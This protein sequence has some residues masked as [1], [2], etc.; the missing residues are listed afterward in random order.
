MSSKRGFSLFSLVSLKNLVVIGMLLVLFLSSAA[1]ASPIIQEPPPT[2]ASSTDA[3]ALWQ[4]YQARFTQ[5]KT[6]F[7][8]DP[9]AALF[10]PVL[11]T[12]FVSSDGKTAVLWLA[13][14]DHTGRIL[15]TEPGIVFALRQGE[16]W[17]IVFSSDEEWTE[18]KASLPEGF[19][20]AEFQSAPENTPD[21][22]GT[23]YL[24]GYYL[25]YVAGTVHRLEGS[26][27]HFHSYPPLGYPSCDVAY[28]RYVYDFTDA[29]H[30]PLVASKAGIVISS[31][32][33]CIDGNTTCTN[34]IILQ[35]TVGSAYQ[36]YLH[37][38]NNTISDYLTAGTF[39]DRGKYIG[40]TDD[41]GYSTSEHVH[42]MIVNG[43]WYGGDG[44]PWG[45]SVDMRFSDVT[46]N[47]GIPRTCY[48]VTNLPIYDGATECNG[49]RSI[50]FSASNDWFISGNVGASPPTGHLTRPVAGATV[51][52]GSNPLMDVTAQTSDDVRVVQAVMIAKVNGSWREVGPRVKNPTAAGVFDWDVNICKAGD[53]NG[54]LEVALKLWDHEGNVTNLLSPRTINV[55]DAC[56]YGAYLP[57]IFSN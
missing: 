57:S 52:I 33:S 13:L 26:V 25:P 7:A 6:L 35:D 41:T 1:F 39:V 47:G 9:L 3:E 23:N 34:Y 29:G 53:I 54:P 8:E 20:P 22:A 55:D 31:R 40:D 2:I 27:L 17:Q 48:E 56:P 38:A 49:D 28:C 36:I 21:Q 45:Y 30:F 5:E 14:K 18:I 19:L 4:A 51:A 11:D 10:E 12:A 44:Y 46:L 43:F 50:P 32:D 42:F 16:G 37:L 15:A 24:T